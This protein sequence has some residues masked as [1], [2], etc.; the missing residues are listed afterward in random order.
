M[1]PTPRI[2]HYYGDAVRIIFVVGAAYILWGLPRMTELLGIPV[3]LS[4]VAVAILGI[5][6]G[7]TNPVQKFSLRMNAV[8][9]VVF[10]ISFA[11]L[12]W[13]SYQESIGG[14]IEFANQL[15]AIL[16]LVASYFSI[17]SLR[18][19]TVPEKN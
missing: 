9:S 18:G 8:V 6:A 17:K 11:Y 7:I 10:L 13:Y 19:A 1:E 2:P 12:S 4:I 14:V 15:G 16:F 5:A 3:I